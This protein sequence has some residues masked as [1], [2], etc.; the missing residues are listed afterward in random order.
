MRQLNK[1]KR[2]NEINKQRMNERRKERMNER[3][4]ECEYLSKS[5]CISI[6]LSIYLSYCHFD[7]TKTKNKIK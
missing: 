7:Y 2:K 5:T 4:E 6:Y 1:Q 3:M